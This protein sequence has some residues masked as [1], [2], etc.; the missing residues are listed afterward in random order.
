MIVYFFR[1]LKSRSLYLYWFGM[2]NFFAAFFILPIWGLDNNITPLILKPV[3]YFLSTGILSWT[4]GWFIYY[5]HPKKITNLYT[6]S[7]IISL[8]LHNAILFLLS[9]RG[10][11]T[12]QYK[13]LLPLD[14]LLFYLMEGC[15][16]Y[17]MLN[18][19][20]VTIHFFFQKKIAT[21]QHFTWSIRMGLLLFLTSSMIGGWMLY[22]MSHA[23]GGNDAESGLF[24]LNWSRKYGDLRVAQ[25]FGV[26]AL[27]VIPLVGYYFLT[28]KKQVMVFSFFYFLIIIT[29]LVLAMMK[30]PFI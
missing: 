16:F 15:M 3:K 7:I 13:N 26:H 20:S 25:F 10:I 18:V 27:Q 22:R 5:L 9:L 19:I 23:I 11:S 17:F 28:T 24:F 6:W 29:F 21:S 8:L 12:L 30:I 1:E 14:S 2:V 4:I